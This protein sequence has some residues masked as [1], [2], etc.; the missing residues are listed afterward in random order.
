MH[1]P[2]G[3]LEVGAGLE[4]VGFLHL[5]GALDAGD[6]GV[7]LLEDVQPELA[8]EV[9][10]LQV[11]L[12]GLVVSAR[13]IQLIVADVVFWPGRAAGQRKERD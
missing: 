7:A 13:P 4:A 12:A 5:V 2:R 6:A 3:D 11:V 9:E 8:D 1:A 10:G